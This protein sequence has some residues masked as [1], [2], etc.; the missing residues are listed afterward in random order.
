M[1]DRIQNTLATEAPAATIIIRL[2]IGG[3][4]LSEGIQKFLFPAE[5]G[6][7]RF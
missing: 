7:G 6:A 1:K 3:I 4:F 2:M 5:L